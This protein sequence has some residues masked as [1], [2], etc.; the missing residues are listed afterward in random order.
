M[1]KRYIE[2]EKARYIRNR[3][4]LCAYSR[5]WAKNNKEKRN[6]TRR[7]KYAKLKALNLLPK[8]KPQ[9]KSKIYQKLVQK[10]YKGEVL[11]HYGG[12]CACCA[13]NNISFLTIDHIDD[14]GKE[15]KGNGKHRYKGEIL[16]RFLIKNNYPKGIQV[17]CFNCN[18]G[19]R[20]NNGTCPHKNK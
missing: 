13:E 15:H 19:K 14:N 6:A 5:Q 11:S 10:K 1:R 7:K 18:I 3:E 8:R 17:L 12:Q 4:K 2:A 20:N 16:Y 9:A